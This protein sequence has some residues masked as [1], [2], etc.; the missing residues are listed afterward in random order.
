[1]NLNPPLSFFFFFQ[2]E[3]GIRDFH[4]TGVQTCALPIFGGLELELMKSACACPVGSPRDQ[5]GTDQDDQGQRDVEPVLRAAHRDTT[6]GTI[7]PMAGEGVGVKAT[8]R[9]L[10]TRMARTASRNGITSFS[11]PSKSPSR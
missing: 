11:I 1:M 3:D 8:V 7:C 10:T 5:A 9:A 4:V 6:R 2:A